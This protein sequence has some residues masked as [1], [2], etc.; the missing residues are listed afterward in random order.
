MPFR[1]TLRKLDVIARFGGEEFVILMPETSPQDAVQIITRVQRELT[2]R[3]FMHNREKLL[4][5][6]SA[7]VAMMSQGEGQA[8]MIKRAD[9]ALYRAK[10][11][12]K[13]RIVMANPPSSP[14]EADRKACVK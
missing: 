3:I 10:N 12:G 5:T 6:F 2:K 4:I 13:N 8:D 14:V 1:E 11:A 7:G 9:A